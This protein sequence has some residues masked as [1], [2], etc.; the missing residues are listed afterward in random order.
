MGFDT[1][2]LLIKQYMEHIR[3]DENLLTLID[4]KI[5]ELFSVYNTYLTTIPGIGPTLGATIFSEI[6]DISKFQSAAKLL[7]AP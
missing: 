3:Y 4:A 5:E 6:G 2:G 7:K 1:H